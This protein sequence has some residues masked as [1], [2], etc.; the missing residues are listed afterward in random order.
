VQLIGDGVS[1]QTRE[2]AAAPLRAHVDFHLRA[3]QSGWYALVVEDRAGRKAY[4]DPIWVV[5]ERA[6]PAQ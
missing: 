2:L 6:A 4:T 5:L 3:R 1:L